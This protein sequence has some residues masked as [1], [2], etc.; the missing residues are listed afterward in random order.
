MAQRS[1]EPVGSVVGVVSI[2]ASFPSGASPV[3]GVRLLCGRNGSSVATD[4][5]VREVAVRLVAGG[6]LR[7][8]ASQER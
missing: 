6:A 1:G 2:S 3:P 4:E 7:E 5:T 8:V